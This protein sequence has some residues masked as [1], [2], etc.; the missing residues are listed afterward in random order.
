MH[1]LSPQI[2]PHRRDSVAELRQHGEWAAGCKLGELPK[3]RSRTAK[4]QPVAPL[5]PR[6]DCKVKANHRT[7]ALE[8]TFAAVAAQLYGIFDAQAQRCTGHY[9]FPIPT[10]LPLKERPSQSEAAEIM[11]QV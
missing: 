4:V 8:D 10:A 6:M 5:R 9:S 11:K 7:C 1:L 3:L 2:L